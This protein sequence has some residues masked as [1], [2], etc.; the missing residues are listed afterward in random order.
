MEPLRRRPSFYNS[1]A[2]TLIK[3]I[4]V[5][6]GSCYSDMCP[7]Y[8]AE[9]DIQTG[10]VM[11]NGRKNV[12]KMGKKIGQMSSYHTAL[13]VEFVESTGFF[14]MNA[15]YSS[16]W[17]DLQMTKITV[18]LTN[19]QRHTVNFDDLARPPQLIAIRLMIQYALGNT[20]WPYHQQ[21]D[22]HN[23]SYLPKGY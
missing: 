11:Y 17:P 15:E 23:I 6:R 21:V 4:I 19:G 13:L 12:K 5:D 22:L 14:R 1:N 16:G 7:S 3:K 8:H 20:R 9:I 2:D 10:R 18:I